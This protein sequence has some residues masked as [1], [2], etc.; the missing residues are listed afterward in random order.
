MAFL[1]HV[2]YASGTVETLTF[3]SRFDRSLV[4]VTLASQPV[5]LR[6]EDRS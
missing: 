5:G 3:R 6:T 1:L 4:M 2:T